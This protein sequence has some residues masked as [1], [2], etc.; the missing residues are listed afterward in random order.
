LECWRFSFFI[1]LR[2]ARPRGGVAAAFFI[3]LGCMAFSY[4]LL[5][6][7]LFDL[8]DEVIDAGD[9]ERTGTDSP[10]SDHQCRRSDSP[11]L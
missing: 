9:R 3:V 1:V 5:K 11:R 8:A 10:F 4:F 6:K 7:M 2:D